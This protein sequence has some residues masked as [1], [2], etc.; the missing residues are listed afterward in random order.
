MICNLSEQIKNICRNDYKYFLYK[1]NVV[2][3]GFGNKFIN[4]INTFEPVIQVFVSKK[5]PANCLSKDDLI[6]AIYKC[7]K[8]DVI[9][10]GTFTP[11]LNASRNPNANNC[12]YP[13][14]NNCK[15]CKNSNN[16]CCS[17][18]ETSNECNFK[19]NLLTQR[20]RPVQ[21]SLG[22]SPTLETTKTGTLSCI[23]IDNKLGNESYCL[24]STN[25]TLAHLNMLKLGTPIIQ[26][27]AMEGGK[28]CQDVIGCLSRYIPIVFENEICEGEKSNNLDAAIASYVKCDAAN[29]INLKVPFIGT[30][31]GITCPKLNN[32]VQW[33]GCISQH[34]KG[35]ILSTCATVRILYP[36]FSKTAIFSDAT[37]ATGNV[38]LGDRGALVCDC[39]A[40]TMGI[41]FGS[42]TDFILVSDIHRVICELDICLLTI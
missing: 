7:I 40:N 29:A 22:V 38:V 16:S 25:T 30:P 5:V 17:C 26:P 20:V 3:V 6:P 8:T 13:C 9:E 2:G 11:G 10:T 36:E 14:A 34:Q 42:S 18:C 21:P 35:T 32:S 41:L 12:S 15:E 33:T 4:G 19:E 27:S 31:H 28:A 23:A 24:L 1:A 37:L 39:C